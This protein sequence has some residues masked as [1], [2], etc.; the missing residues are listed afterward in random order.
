MSEVSTEAYPS[1]S[2]PVVMCVLRVWLCMY[3]CVC[4]YLSCLSELMLYI[5]WLRCLSW[6]C[7]A[8]LSCFYWVIHADTSLVFYHYRLSFLWCWKTRFRR[9]SV[10]RWQKSDVFLSSA[11]QPDRLVSD[12][13]SSEIPLREESYGQ[14]NMFTVSF[15]WYLFLPPS[16][17][18]SI[19]PFL[20][21]SLPL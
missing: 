14:T 18:L 3:V 1:P 10:E 17:H 19:Y 16:L 5:G 8:L 7:S 11:V 15:C 9:K 20:S 6:T 2:Q 13:Y 4:V 12:L 21:T